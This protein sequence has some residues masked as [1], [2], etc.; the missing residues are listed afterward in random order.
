MAS[1]GPGLGP[2]GGQLQE[3]TSSTPFPSLHVVAESPGSVSLA[4]VCVSFRLP[5]VSV[6]REGTPREV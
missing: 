3:A 1:W 2:G 5:S 4:G 6:D